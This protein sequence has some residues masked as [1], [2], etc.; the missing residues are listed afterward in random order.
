LRGRVTVE[1]YQHRVVDFRPESIIN[2]D[3]IRLVAVSRELNA[4]GKSLL[5]IGHEMITRCRVARADEPA[6]DKFC[7]R[8]ERN[9]SPNIATAFCSLFGGAVLFLRV[10]KRP[11]FIALYSA[12]FQIAQNFV[13]IFR[14][15]AAKTA[16]QL[17]DR[18]FSNTR[19]SD[20]RAD[21]VS[22][23]Q[24]G[25]DLRSL[26]GAQFVHAAIMLERSSIRKLYFE[27]K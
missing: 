12:A 20:S 7:V 15:G 22:L 6:R 9:P 13:L 26:F 24:A 27:E 1:F 25:N 16:Q 3:Q 17:N 10:N 23:D 4:I 21:T 11:N 18:I 14:A 8:V 5:Q 19:H 2:G